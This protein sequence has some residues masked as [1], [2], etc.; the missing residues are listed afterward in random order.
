MNNLNI[1]IRDEIDNYNIGQYAV[2]TLGLET[3][4]GLRPSKLELE[5]RA[6]NMPNTSSLQGNLQRNN[7]GQRGL[8]SS[9]QTS[10]AIFAPSMI[11]STAELV[12]K[13]TR[14]PAGIKSDPLR[15]TKRVKAGTKILANSEAVF[16]GRLY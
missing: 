12:E 15:S 8:L 11:N 7:I 2:D 3:K 1:V 6:R 10:Q 13:Y 5:M 14:P 9:V 4:S 16:S